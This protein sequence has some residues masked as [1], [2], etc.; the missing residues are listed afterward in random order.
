MKSGVLVINF[1][2]PEEATPE[3]VVPFL[4]RI[5]LTNAALEGR[6]PDEAHRT[7]SRQL[8]GSRAPGLIAEYDRIGGSPLNAQA[9]AQSGA[10]EGELRRRGLDAACYPVFQ[11]L[12]PFVEEGVRRARQ[13]GVERLVALPVYPL[14]G[15]STTVAALR[16]VRRAVE[17]AGWEVGV[18]EIAGWHRHP[19]YLPMHADHVRAF[20]GERGVDLSAETTTLLF[21]VH[22]TP[23]KYL[24]GGSRY[25]R[26]V[27]ESCD[28][29]A[30]MVGV[31]RYAIG[32]QNHTNRPIDWTQP[33]VED[34]VARIEARDLVVVALSFMHEQSET[35]AELD[36][37]LRSHAE[38]RGM[39]FHRVPV[40]HDSPRFVAVLADLTEGVLD[41]GGD[42]GVEWRRCLCRGGGKALCTNGMRLDTVPVSV[43]TPRRGGAR[44]PQRD[45]TLPGG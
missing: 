38:R 6:A 34:A 4:E 2:E 20:A 12:D 35:L 14:C 31:E 19:D 18:L 40:P 28:V 43:G 7:R 11:F 42:H 23:L 25:D 16:E 26:Y 3:A 29:L 15:H 22:G 37:E 44:L 39:A 13:D 36:L 17:A 9:R 5:F 33:D 8:A 24:E 21:S 45:A 30:G 10:L 1:G 41:T 27:E 32:Y